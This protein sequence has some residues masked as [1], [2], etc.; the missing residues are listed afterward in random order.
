MIKGIVFDF[1]GTLANS[2]ISGL[3]GFNYAYEKM[4]MTKP[5]S[6]EIKKYFGAG[7]DRIFHRLLGD[8]PKALEAFEHYKVYRTENPFHSTWHTG[9]EELLEKIAVHQIPAAI[10]TGRHSEDLD[11]VSQHLGLAGR[12]VKVVCDN[13]VQASKPSPEGIILAAAALQLLPSEIIYV[14]DS[15]SDIEAAHAAGAIA[16]AALWDQSAIKDNFQ[17]KPDHWA[18]TPEEL[19]QIFLK[20]STL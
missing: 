13:H 3:D 12:F 4:G 16:V 1:D 10:V 2:L 17:T 19:W 8:W 20:Y 15:S 6:A 5:E 11:L 18:H 14:G 9:V 7:A